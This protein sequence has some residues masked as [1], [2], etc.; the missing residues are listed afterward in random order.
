MLLSL[1]G[2]ILLGAMAC[3]G[4]TGC[5]S[6]PTTPNGTYSIQVTATA[7]SIAQSATFSLAAQ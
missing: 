3:T 5:G 1:S 6:G 2:L 4:I 7:G